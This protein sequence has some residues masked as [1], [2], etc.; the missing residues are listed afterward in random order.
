MTIKRHTTILAIASLQVAAASA[1]EIPDSTRSAMRVVGMA[2]AAVSAMPVLTGAE[3]FD[4]AAFRQAL[5]DS[6]GDTPYQAFLTARDVTDFVGGATT[7]S[8]QL[9]SYEIG[10]AALEVNW[11][12]AIL[13]GDEE[14]ARS[15]QTECNWL[16]GQHPLYLSNVADQPSYVVFAS[17][18]YQRNEASNLALSIRR[19]AADVNIAAHIPNAIDPEGF[20]RQR[21]Q[22]TFRRLTNSAD[23]IRDAGEAY[24][25]Y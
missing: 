13:L 23:F 21:L 16:L 22:S 10:W 12:Y 20:V 19:V 17:P 9:A 25:Y 15:I 7:Y 2:R 4:V 11:V 18:F 5:R 8:A 6:R 24:S 14:Q 3:G 1:A